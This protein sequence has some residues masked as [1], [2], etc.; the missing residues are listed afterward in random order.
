MAAEPRVQDAREATRRVVAHHEP[1][2]MAEPSE[3]VRLKLRVL[4]D[5]APE[6][7]R[8]GD[9]DPDLHVAQLCTPRYLLALS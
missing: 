3:R 7:P 5:G 9:D 1:Y 4:D 6:R 8:V 2:V